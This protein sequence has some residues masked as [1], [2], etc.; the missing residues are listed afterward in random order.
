MRV[1]RAT[2]A[3]P[4]LAAPILPRHLPLPPAPRQQDAVDLADQPAR[5]GKA[6]AQTLEAMVERPD[7]VRDLDHVLQGNAGRLLQL[8][9][10]E[11]RE[12]GLRALD[13]GGE[14]RLPAH[15]RVEKE[16]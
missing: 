9:E 12:R 7:I 16:V 4:V 6:S 1:S 5:Q 2:A 11:I 8:E 15:I 13:L 3:D 14:H 10:E